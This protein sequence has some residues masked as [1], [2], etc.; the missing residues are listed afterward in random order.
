MQHAA[1]YGLLLTVDEVQDMAVHRNNNRAKAALMCI[2]R[3][4]RNGTLRVPVMLLA[5][6]LGNSMS[7]LGDFG[8]SRLLGGCLHNL[9]G[10]DADAERRVIRDW[11]VISGGVGRNVQPHILEHWVGTIAAETD[12]WPQ[13]IHTFAPQAAQWLQNHGSLMPDA[14]PDTVMETGRKRKREYYEQRVLAIEPVY[15]RELALMS[16][17]A[18]ERF[19]MRATD[20]LAGFARVVFPDGRHPGTVAREVFAEA[21]RKGLLAEGKRGD[22]QIPIPSMRRWL[23]DCYGERGLSLDNEIGGAGGER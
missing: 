9:G 13:H 21:I 12:G 5:G 17:A 19:G 1:N 15:R 8:L 10:L 16:A 6:G 14:V 23:S 11:I 18:P 2:I 7:V 3:S 4:I 20:V 22:Y